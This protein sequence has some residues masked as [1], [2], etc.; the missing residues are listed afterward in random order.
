MSNDE[1]KFD[2]WRKEQAKKRITKPGNEHLRLSKAPPPI[3]PNRGFK[4]YGVTT[5]ITPPAKTPD[6]DFWLNMPEV[7]LW[8]AVA[9]SMNIDPDSL[10]HSGTAWMAGP[11]KWSIFT[12]DSFSSSEQQIIFDKRLRLLVANKSVKNGFS[13]GT[14]SM[15]DPAYHS[16][17]QS[18]FSPWAQSIGWD[19]PAELAAM[20][21]KH[22]EQAGA[23]AAQNDAPV[24]P[25]KVS[26]GDTAEDDDS[27]AQLADLFDPVTVPTLE[28]M[29]PAGGKWKQWA[30]RAKRNG[31]DKCRTGRGRFN[32]Y[33]AAEW[34]LL[35]GEPD[36]DKDKC[37]RK[38]A[39]NLP[40]R[41]FDSRN[42]LTGDLD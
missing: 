16:V 3:T 22:G 5:R 33:L 35:Q 12:N 39:K 23:P 29:F 41:S 19:I 30:E 31:L 37:R 28:K 10:K 15:D 18:E 8:Q 14:L 9:L 1:K 21:R 40:A 13:P 38:L 34:F 20:A 4:A 11:G 27:E 17:R 7:K 6:W 24:T 2:E 26:P 32:P 42:L 36:W 25:A